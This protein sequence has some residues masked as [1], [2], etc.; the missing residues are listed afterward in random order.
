MIPR[1]F[2]LQIA[3]VYA[4][5]TLVITL[6]ISPYFSIGWDSQIFA[7]VGRAIIDNGNVF[8]LYQ[9]SHQT[10]GDWG[11]PYPPLYA[12]LLAPV[13]ALSVLAPALPD[14]L[15]VRVVPVVFDVIV[16]VLIALIIRQRG[17]NRRLSGLGAALWLF[18]P[19]TLYQTAIQAHQEST[20]LACVLAAYALMRGSERRGRWAVLPSL[21]MACAVTLKQSAI[22]F[23]IPYGVLLLLAPAERLRRLTAAAVLFALVFGG[24]SLPYHLYSPDFFYLVFVDV[25]NMPVQTQSAVVWLLGLRDYL[26]DQTRSG[27]FLLR[28]QAPLTIALAAL[29][30]LVALRRDRD[31]FRLGLLTALVF[32][33][34]SKKVMGYHYPLL[35]PFLLIYALPQFRFDLVAIAVLAATWIIVSPYFAPWAKPEHMPLYAALGTPNTLLWVWLFAH[36]WRRSS[37]LRLRRLDLTKRLRDGGATVSAIL[38]VT[39]IMAI[40]AM[41]QPWANVAAGAQFLLLAGLIAAASLVAVV[42]AP[43]LWPAPVRLGP[44]HA[45]LA[46]LLAPVYFAAF[47]LTQESTSLIEKLLP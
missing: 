46:A 26:I 34:T 15:A 24:L 45:V 11:F 40:A 18:N 20:W 14:W 31:L 25:A 47:A 9:A 36:V 2:I 4:L 5:L 1:R 41:L 29:T 30:A 23:Y 37:A 8:D 22:L 13:L 32:F 35:V 43:R 6:A 21:L 19:L 33:L 10:W 3:A 12:H 7:Q 44:G 16:A 38:L 39:A 27:F 28:Y 42:L 17:G